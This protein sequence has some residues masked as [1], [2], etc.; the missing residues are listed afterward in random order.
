MAVQGYLLSSLLLPRACVTGPTRQREW[1]LPGSSC[2]RIGVEG[3]EKKH[4]CT[5][6]VVCIR[7]WPG[8][9]CN[10]SKHNSKDRNGTY[11]AFVP[12]HALSYLHFCGPATYWSGPVVTRHGWVRGNQTF[13]YKTYCDNAWRGSMAHPWLGWSC[14][15]SLHSPLEVEVVGCDGCRVKMLNVELRSFR[16]I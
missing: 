15:Y 7:Q 16:C 13:L 11:L 9:F 6:V 5:H 2:G 10:I 8:I 3:K 4:A 14:F 12:F 1:A